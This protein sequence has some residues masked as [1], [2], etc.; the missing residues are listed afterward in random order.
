MSWRTMGRRFGSQRSKSA[1][2]WKMFMQAEVRSPG[3]GAGMLRMRFGGVHAGFV[4]WEL[5]G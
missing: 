2:A 4:N 3:L 1:V 5:C